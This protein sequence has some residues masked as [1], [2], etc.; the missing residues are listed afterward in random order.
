VGD[1][2]RDVYV[3]WLELLKQSNRVGFD[4]TADKHR[5]ELEAGTVD[6]I[7]CPVAC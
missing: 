2:T 5:C 4:L 6:L 1:R 7:N 3:R